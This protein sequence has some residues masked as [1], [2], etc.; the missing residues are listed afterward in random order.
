MADANLRHLFCATLASTSRFTVIACHRLPC[1]VAMP[2]SFNALTR[3]AQPT[4]GLPNGR[5]GH[6]EQIAFSTATGAAA[7]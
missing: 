6:S 1:G 4:Y 3:R 5:G 2:R 7:N